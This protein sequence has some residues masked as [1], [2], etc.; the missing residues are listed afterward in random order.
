VQDGVLQCANAT[1]INPGFPINIISNAEFRIYQLAA[2]LDRPFSLSDGRINVTGGSGSQNLLG[3]EITLN[4]SGTL[5]VGSGFVLTA[6]NNIKGSGNLIKT[7]AGQLLL[8][9]VNTYTGGTIVDQGTLTLNTVASIAA[10]PTIQLGT[11][12]TLDVS[13]VSPWIVAAS[14]TLS[15]DGNVN[16]GVSILGSLVPGATIGTLTFNNDLTLAGTTVMEV[17]RDG[18]ATNDVINVVGALAVGGTLKIVTA[19]ASPLVVNDIFKLFNFTSTP[20]GSF[21]QVILP[22]EYTW[23]TSR[24]NTEG[25]LT[26]TGVA[27]PP[28]L[29]VVRTGNSL[30]FTWSGAYKLQ[31]QTNALNIGISSNWFDYPGGSNSGIT[32]P[33]SDNNGTV[34]FRLIGQ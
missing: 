17:T 31:A 27:A 30:Q 13:A 28:I 25:T 20:T 24:L 33:I 14:Q 4:Q 23:D 26:V 3:G 2:P 15:G 6:T 12:A 32:V 8:A 22:A 29:G 18:G 19:G 1:V 34:F 9:A 7:G 5:Q 16:G 11:N 21:A 10:S